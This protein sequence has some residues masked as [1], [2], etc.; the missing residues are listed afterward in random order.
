M[1]S[2]HPLPGSIP[3]SLVVGSEFYVHPPE[4]SLPSPAAVSPASAPVLTVEQRPK[5]S[6]P[7][8]RIENNPV[9]NPTNYFRFK[10]AIDWIVTAAMMTLAVPIM[11]F[12][13]LAILVCDG[14]PITFRQVRVGKQ[15]R[16]FRIWKFRTM[17]TWCRRPNRCGVEQ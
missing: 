17:Q 13:A 15:G 12:V 5:L 1:Q 7:I 6:S 3:T 2:P 16:L 10:H 11:L 4:Q 14:R 9:A 8:S